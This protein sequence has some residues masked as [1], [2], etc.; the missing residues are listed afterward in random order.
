M[1]DIEIHLI[2]SGRV[3]GVYYRYSTETEAKRLGLSGWVKNLP[4]GAVEAAI[5][6]PPERVE[7]LVD[8]CWQGPPAAQVRDIKRENLTTLNEY[9]S[10]KTVY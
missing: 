2:I 1:T 10:F 9:E 4:N 7:Q 3:Q 5:K 6:G 8:W